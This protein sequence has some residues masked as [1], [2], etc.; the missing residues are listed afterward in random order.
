MPT[1]Y[2]EQP[3]HEV[4]ERTVWHSTQHVRQVMSLLERE[5][6]EVDQPLGKDAI[7]GLP[8][9]DKVWDD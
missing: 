6:V 3:T 4:L 1:Y 5:G 2:G 7:A 8:L 9:T